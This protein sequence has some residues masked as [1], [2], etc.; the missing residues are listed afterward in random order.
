M[1]SRQRSRRNFGGRHDH[2][3]DRADDGAVRLS[4]AR[5]VRGVSRIRLGSLADLGRRPAE[6]R[7]ATP[8]RARLRGIHQSSARQRRS[9]VGYRR[10]TSR[11]RGDA[12][13]RDGTRRRRRHAARRYRQRAT[14]VS[15]YAP[16]RRSRRGAGRLVLGREPHQRAGAPARNL[17]RESGFSVLDMNNPPV[18][19]THTPRRLS[20]SGMR[21]VFPSSD[22][23][24]DLVYFERM[25]NCQFASV[26]ILS[27]RGARGGALSP[28]D[29]GVGDADRQGS[30]L[31]LFDDAR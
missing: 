31:Q 23:S 27:A 24:G 28:A 12:R 16:N 1:P 20:E 8:G 19:S 6:R 5:I 30:L 29:T 9:F 14:G 3:I 26:T 13:R 7:S 4:G 17:F 18:A 15:R 11:A 25:D 10:R 22:P 21:S 2:A